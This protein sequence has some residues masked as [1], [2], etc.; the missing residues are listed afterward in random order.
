M[1]ECEGGEKETRGER[2]EKIVREGK[3]TYERRK[4]IK[5]RRKKKRTSFISIA[6]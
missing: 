1:D 2:K 5:E 4:L 3:K 6:D